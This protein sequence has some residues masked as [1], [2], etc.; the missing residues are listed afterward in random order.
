M[1]APRDADSQQS[2]IL[3]SFIPPDETHEHWRWV[4]HPAL[5]AALNDLGWFDEQ[6]LPEFDLEDQPP[7]AIEGEI[8]RAWRNHRR[9]EHMLRSAKIRAAIDSAP[10][11]RLRC[12]VPG[13]QFDF[14]HRYGELGEGFAEVHHLRPLSEMQAPETVTLDDLAVLCANC[15]RM[16]HRGGRILSLEELGMHLRA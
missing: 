4:M 11:R 16:I 2:A 1:Q 14:V 3:A 15:H 7:A 5:A 10:D 8:R 9:R 6:G 13:C 12:E